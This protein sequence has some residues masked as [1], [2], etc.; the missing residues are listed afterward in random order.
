MPLINSYIN[1]YI[2]LIVT[3]QQI[4]RSSTDGQVPPFAITD[5]KLYVSDATLSTQNNIKPL[6]QLKSGFKRTISCN[7][8]QSKAT[9]KTQNQYLDYLIDASFQGVNRLFVY[10]LEIIHIEQVTR[11]FLPTAKR[12]DYNVMIDSKSIFDQP[13]KNNQRTYENIKKLQLNTNNKYTKLL[14]ILQPFIW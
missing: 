8:Y 10:H 5:T 3:W 11:Y 7:K 1:S 12:K 9:I 4:G 14:M 13:V 2:N 6:G